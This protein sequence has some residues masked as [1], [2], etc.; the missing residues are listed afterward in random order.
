MGLFN[1]NKKKDVIVGPSG[2]AYTNEEGEEDSDHHRRT[3]SNS[4]N[5]RRSVDQTRTST[6]SSSRQ[7]RD[8]GI[9]AGAVAAGSTAAA[10]G[11]GGG[12]RK[13]LE[14]NNDVTR[15]EEKERF[16]SGVLPQSSTTQASNIPQQSTTSP[17]GVASTRGIEE[18]PRERIVETAKAPHAHPGRER[19]SVLSEEDARMRGTM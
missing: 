3:S 9:G 11:G 18:T 2:Y 19:D 10:I 15:G 8:A 14:T 17:V 13:S 12:G 6:D 4:S 5:P 1:H 16:T 7:H